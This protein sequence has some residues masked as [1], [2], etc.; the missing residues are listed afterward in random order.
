[1]N[2]L[3]TRYEFKWWKPWFRHRLSVVWNHEIWAKVED[4]MY[5]HPDVSMRIFTRYF[6]YVDF[7]KKTDLIKF[8]LSGII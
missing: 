3:E 8:K 1:M 5:S 6:G 4:Y 2:P 7:H